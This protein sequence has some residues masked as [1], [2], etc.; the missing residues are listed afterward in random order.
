MKPIPWEGEA[1]TEDNPLWVKAKLKW[2]ALFP[3][4]RIADP[5]EIG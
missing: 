3:S 2:K 5:S 4:G 1:I